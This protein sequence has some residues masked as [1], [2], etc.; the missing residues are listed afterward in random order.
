VNWLEIVLVIIGS[1]ALVAELVGLVGR[2]LDKPWGDLISP[3]MRR[4]GCRWLSIPFGWGVLGG[5]WFGMALG[6][7]RTWW[8]DVLLVGSLVGVL[9]R[10][11]FIRTRVTKPWLTPIFFAGSLVGWFLW[12]QS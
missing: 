11:L 3:I 10:D 2:K 4:D 1:V 6:Y 8:L 7:R 9:A 12:N 5:H